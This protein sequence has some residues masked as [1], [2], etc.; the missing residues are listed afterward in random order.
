MEVE[1]MMGDK[2][3]SC[4]RKGNV[5]K[6]CVTPACTNGLETMAITEKQENGKGPSLRKTT[7]KNNRGS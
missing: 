4:K 2:Y 7:G 5:L 3:I 6:S 1:G